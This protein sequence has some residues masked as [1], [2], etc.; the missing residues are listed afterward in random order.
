[1]KMPIQPKGHESKYYRTDDELGD[2]CFNGCSLK[3]FI[4]L[5]ENKNFDFDKVELDVYNMMGFRVYEDTTVEENRIEWI[6]YMKKEQEYNEWAKDHKGEQ[7]KNN[8]KNQIEKLQDQLKE[9]EK[10]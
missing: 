2:K 5:C 4:E 10:E 6:E 8:I 3:E 9:M 7:K 1:M